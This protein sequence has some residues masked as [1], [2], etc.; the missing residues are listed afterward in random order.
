MKQLDGKV[1]VVLGAAGRD[2]MGQVIARLFAQEGARVVVAG[3]HADTLEALAQ[4]I[5]GRHAVCDITRKQDVEALAQLGVDAYGR[6]DIAIN[7]TGWGLMAKLRDTTEE[8][9][10]RLMD[11]Q[12]KGVF[13]FLQVFAERLAACGG[14]SIVTMS[15]ASVHALLFNHAAY[16][17]TKAGA[18]A[19][20]RCFAN[21][22]GARGVK[23]NA[24]APGFTTTPMTERES[25]MPG[26]QEA[27]VKEYPLG[28][29]GTT[30]DVATAA[31]WL[32][33][34]DSFMTGQ[35]L[36]INGGLTL[37]RNPLPREINA[38][39]AAAAA[40]PRPV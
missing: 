4:A 17:G 13:F 28:R 33:G 20:V 9:L 8:Q 10:D 21:E 29:L 6:V 30:R 22:Y 7:C 5:Q 1:A 24:L 16:I 18:D 12:F 40:V 39:L 2:N 25:T 37:R 15:S 38:A 3:R 23:V 32:A 26:L 35:V 34:P 31:L 11:L 36:Q 19:L 27:F 14:G